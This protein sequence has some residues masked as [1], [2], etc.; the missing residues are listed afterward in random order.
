[1]YLYIR[2]VTDKGTRACVDHGGN[3]A[4]MNVGEGGGPG[5]PGE[6]GGRDEQ[7]VPSSGDGQTFIGC[8]K[9]KKTGSAQHQ[10]IVMHRVCIIV[11]VNML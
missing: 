4:T 5:P 8:Q 11:R 9:T 2:S 1:M 6:G 7:F 3:E 10:D